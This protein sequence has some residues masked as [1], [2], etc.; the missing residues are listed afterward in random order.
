MSSHLQACSVSVI[1][2]FISLQDTNGLSYNS[3]FV[4]H[5]FSII[6]PISFR[7]FSIVVEAISPSSLK[8]LPFSSTI[9]VLIM[10]PNSLNRFVVSQS[11]AGS[12]VNPPTKLASHPCDSL[13]SD[14][15]L[16]VVE[17][18]V[19]ASHCTCSLIVVGEGGCDRKKQKLTREST[20]L[21]GCPMDFVN[22]SHFLR[23]NTPR[24]LGSAPP[25]L[26]I[27]CQLVRRWCDGLRSGTAPFRDDSHPCHFRAFGLFFLAESFL[28]I[29]L[30]A[31]SEFG[32]QRDREGT[33]AGCVRSTLV[34]L[35]KSI[36]CSVV[37]SSSR[38]AVLLVLSAEDFQ[39]L[40]VLLGINLRQQ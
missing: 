38:I 8:N 28:K 32:A 21:L 17:A 9:F 26:N 5:F 36:L 6:L 1:Q 34:L 22:G 15:S 35:S 19:V 7:F 25:Y 2:A 3:S 39:V 29:Q 14:S 24:I 31:I 33:V 12:Q 40:V 16:I 18:I 37:V 27:L 4:F 11:C 10:S 30:H 20:M 23:P 13:E